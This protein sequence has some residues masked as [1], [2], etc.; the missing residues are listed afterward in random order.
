MSAATRFLPE[1]SV[2]TLSVSQSLSYNW[3]Y[4]NTR[5]RSEPPV[6][7]GQPDS[8]SC[9]SRASSPWR[10]STGRFRLSRGSGS[11]RLG[12]RRTA[13]S[14]PRVRQRG[15]QG[16]DIGGLT[17]SLIVSRSTVRCPIVSVSMRERRTIKRPTAS[18]PI[19]SAPI[20]K[21]PTAAAPN[22]TAPMDAAESARLWGESGRSGFAI[23]PSLASHSGPRHGERLLSR[24]GTIAARASASP[25][26]RL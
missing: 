12:G 13:C 23:P 24:T 4:D 22:A 17:D 1:Q 21:A 3:D 15:P 2:E 10:P 11:S 19:A 7:R 25:R 9:W 8:S 14:L 18:R 6:I 26:A 16:R 5:A 20:A